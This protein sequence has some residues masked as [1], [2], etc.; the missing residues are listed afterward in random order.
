M[1]RAGRL[2]WTPAMLA[3]AISAVAAHA[4]ATCNVKDYGAKGDG[5]TKDTA[6]IQTAIDACVKKGGGTVV[7]AA[8]TYVSAPIVLGSR[9]TLH[10]EKGA[11]LLG[12]PDHADYPPKVEFKVPDAQPLISAT[13][14]RNIAITGEGT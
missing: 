3:L 6:A 2:A 14:A 11:T 9:I 10:L 1:R 8:G 12:S 7:L 4:A 5:A 13:N